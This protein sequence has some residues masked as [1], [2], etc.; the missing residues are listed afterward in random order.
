MG[1][2]KS[3]ARVSAPVAMNVVDVSV[4][5]GRWHVRL[6]EKA[7]K[8]LDIPRHHRLEECLRD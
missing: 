4:R 1:D 2:H 6:H 3:F 7:G 5:D 8:V